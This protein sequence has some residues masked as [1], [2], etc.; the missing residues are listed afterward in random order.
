MIT[1]YSKTMK[2]S[3]WAIG[4]I[5]QLSILEFYNLNKFIYAE[6]VTHEDIHVHLSTMIVARNRDRRKARVSLPGH[7]TDNDGDGLCKVSQLQTLQSIR[8]CVFLFRR[9]HR[10]IRRAF[11]RHAYEERR[12][13]K[14]VLYRISRLDSST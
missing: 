8:T 10:Q 4:E 14:K 2:Y 11:N 1:K 5:T 13:L 3:I 6:H 9:K 7:V 12:R